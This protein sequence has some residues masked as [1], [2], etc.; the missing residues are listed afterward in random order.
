MKSSENRRIALCFSRLEEQEKKALIPYIT[1]GDPSKN[2]TVRLMKK[3]VTA[4]ADIIELGVP[5]SDPGADGTV[6]RLAHERA[7]LNN[8]TLA[9]VFDVVSEFRRSDVITPIVLM[10]YLNPIE[11]LGYDTFSRQAHATGVDGLLVVDCPPEYATSLM[12]NLSLY[13][14]DSVFLVAPTTPESRISIICEVTSGYVYYVSLKGVTGSD[15]LDV[16]IVK[17]QTTLI[18][19]LSKL[20]VCVGFGIRDGKTAAAISHVADGVI[21]GTALVNEVAKSDTVEIGCQLVVQKITEMRQKM[22]EI[23]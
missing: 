10:S 15:N 23:K 20:P 22:D 7:L 12:A 6:I 18:K 14:I 19:S 5:F 11:I 17:Q 4:G 21:V 16:D 1:A 8:T 2:V 3:M 13:N 9:D